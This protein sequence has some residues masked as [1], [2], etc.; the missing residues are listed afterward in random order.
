MRTH[1]RVYRACA[2]SMCNAPTRV[3]ALS[4][5]RA[6]CCLLDAGPRVA[7]TRSCQRPEGLHSRYHRKQGRVSQAFSTCVFNTFN[8]TFLEGQW[9]SLN[10]GLLKGLW[11]MLGMLWSQDRPT[12]SKDGPVTWEVLSGG[13][14]LVSNLVKAGTSPRAPSLPSLDGTHTFPGRE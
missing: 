2:K 10:R 5:P 12:R 14:A 13:L 9:G 8:K 11:N 1:D 4:S 6:R 7:G 3:A